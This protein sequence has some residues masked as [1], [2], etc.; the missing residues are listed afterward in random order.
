MRIQTCQAENLA[1][2]MAKVKSNFGPGAI[3]L[4]VRKIEAQGADSSLMVEG[5]VGYE[6][7]FDNNPSAAEIFKPSTVNNPKIPLNYTPLGGPASGP[8]LGSRSS[9]T[10]RAWAEQHMA[11]KP[12]STQPPEQPS[13]LPD[14]APINDAG[15][16]AR[17][18]YAAE[19]N[20]TNNTADKACRPFDSKL[21]ALIGLLGVGKTTTAAKIAGQFMKK[22]DEP[23]GVISTDVVRPGGSALLKAYAERLKLHSTTASSAPDLRNR[24]ARWNSRGPLIIDTRGCGSRDS[25]AISRLG[26][27]LDGV[28]MPVKKYLVLSATEHKAVARE[29]LDA[30]S[31]LDYSGVILA[32]VD[33]SAGIGDCLEEVRKFGRDVV[34]AGTGEQVPE[35][36]METN[37]TALLALENAR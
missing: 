32:R 5:M 2:L 34:L 3:L 29:A 30:Y 33:Q 36:L 13:T 4:A 27:L 26:S 31:E 18:R 10:L 1:A 24:V 37:S 20:I 28:E 11:A 15:H 16:S 8:Q 14:S 6:P 23:V 22:T 7:E 19:Q 17:R 9:S 35:D 12:P 21:I 25:L